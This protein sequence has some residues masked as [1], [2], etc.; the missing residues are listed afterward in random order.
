MTSSI[1]VYAGKTAL[2]RLRQ[3]GFKA[4]LFNRMAG[5]SGGPKWFTLFGLDKYIFGEFF[6]DRKTPIYTIGSSAGSW[7]MACFAQKDPV[8]AIKRLAKYYSHETYSDKPSIQEISDKAVVLV[9]RFLQQDGAEEIA[10]NPI[11]QSHF[12]IAKAIGLAAS[13]NPKVQM[14]GLL[15]AAFANAFSK[16]NLHYFFERHIVY[17]QAASANFSQA[18]F[19]FQPQRTQYAALSKENV[20][21]V[22]LASGAIPMVLRGISD[23]PGVQPGVYRDGGIIDYHLDID[24]SHSKEPSPQATDT[25]TELQEIKTDSQGLVLYPHFFP[26]VKPG[27]FDK[28]LPY[29]RAN[30]K[31]FDQLVMIT[32]SASHVAS[33]PYQKISDRNDFK[34]LDSDTRIAYWQTVLSES[35]RMAED[36]AKLVE[37]GE[38]MD[39]VQ[40]IEP[41]L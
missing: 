7:R 38:G 6:K 24:F 19:N 32:P 4:A 11:V 13:E 29:R 17:N 23:I 41:I 12:I 5:A 2:K 15:T 39:L 28:S 27:W 34:Y 21:Q 26:Q 35:E 10:N 22:L 18:Y 1:S 37:T 20:K 30:P 25:A 16:N 40:P 14:L 8:A 36:F 31:N 9:D 3:E 33:L